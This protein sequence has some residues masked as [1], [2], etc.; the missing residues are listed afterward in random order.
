M[1]TVKVSVDDGPTRTITILFYSG[2][3]SSYLTDL[4]S[5]SL[6]V[7]VEARINVRSSYNGGHRGRIWT[8]A[9]TFT[10]PALL[11]TELSRYPIMLYH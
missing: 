11:S 9:L 2:T 4:L 5:L 10:S 3:W 1:V 6:V 8:E 7:T